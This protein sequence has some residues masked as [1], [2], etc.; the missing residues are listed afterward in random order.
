MSE[1]A[2]VI[3]IGL[4]LS[5]SASALYIAADLDRWWAAGRVAL[6]TLGVY[7]LVFVF[8]RLMRFFGWWD[9]EEVL[10]FNTLM[11]G[12]FAA[13]FAN[14]VFMQFVWRKHGLTVDKQS[15]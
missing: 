2:Q 7:Q 14:I 8:S 1:L 15:I 11:A 6:V 9:A 3:G 5:I 12:A 10:M 13:I 4:V